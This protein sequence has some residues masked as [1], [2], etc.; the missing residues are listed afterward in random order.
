MM[1]G[2]GRTGYG[3]ING[4]TGG[5]AGPPQHAPT[6]RPNVRPNVFLSYWGIKAEG[7]AAAF[8]LYSPIPIPITQK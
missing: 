1:V 7:G 5:H 2:R 3:R 6:I 8:R 4:L